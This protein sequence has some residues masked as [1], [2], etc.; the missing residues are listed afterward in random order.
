MLILF[1]RV[2]RETLMSRRPDPEAAQDAED[3]IEVKNDVPDIDIAEIIDED[4]GDN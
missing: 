3:S 4:G 1:N 2:E